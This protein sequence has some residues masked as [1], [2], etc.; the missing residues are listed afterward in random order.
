[1]GPIAYYLGML[2]ASLSRFDAA[3]HFEVALE[4]AERRGARPYPQ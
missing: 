1:M 4:S 3:R 2:A